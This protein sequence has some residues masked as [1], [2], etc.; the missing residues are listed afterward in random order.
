LG[1]GKAGLAV[2][3]KD[4][5]GR[6]IIMKTSEDYLVRVTNKAGAN[7]DIAFNLIWYEPS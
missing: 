3:D 2:G 6:E 4:G 7:A 5:F 1:S